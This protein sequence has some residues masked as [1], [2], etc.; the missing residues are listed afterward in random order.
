MSF[1]DVIKKLIYFDIVGE[2]ITTR[3]LLML[4]SFNC[5]HKMVYDLLISDI[6]LVLIEKKYISLSVDEPIIV[7]DFL[8]L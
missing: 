8:M 5:Y 2:S 1:Q 4:K 7:R 3:D 6:F